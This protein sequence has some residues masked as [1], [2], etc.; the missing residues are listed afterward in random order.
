[1]SSSSDRTAGEPLTLRRAKRWLAVVAVVLVPLA[2]AFN[3]WIDMALVDGFHEGEYL[4]NGPKMRAYYAGLTAFPVLIHGAMD[5]LP[6]LAAERIAGLDRVIVWTRFINTA[7]VAMCWVLWMRVPHWLLRDKTR[8]PAWYLV[9]AL[10]FG[11]MAISAGTDPVAKQQAFLG[12][13]DVFLVVMV[14]LAAWASTIVRPGRAALVYV[15]TGA[16]AAACLYWSYDRGVIAFACVVLII[17]SL[18]LMKKFGQASGLAAG[19]CIVLAVVSACGWAGTLGENVHNVQYWLRYSSDVWRLT[20][21]N[22]IYAL[23]GVA[24]TAV[25][26]LVVLGAAVLQLARRQLGNLAPLATALVAAQLVF[27]SKMS[28]LAPFPNSYYTVWPA[29]LLLLIVS[30]RWPAIDAIAAGVAAFGER[31]NNVWA[32]SRGATLQ[33]VALAGLVLMF[34]AN[35]IGGSVIL[36]KKLAKPPEDRWLITAHRFG[37]DDVD[38]RGASCIFQ[39]ANEGIFA[40]VAGKPFCTS[41][42][43]AVYIAKHEEAGVLEEMRRNP[44]PLIVYDNHS[45]TMH[46]YYRTMKE[47]LPAI[48]RFIQENYDIKSSA[49]GYEFALLKATPQGIKAP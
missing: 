13:R 14:A 35:T 5:F 42:G 31:W 15:A 12:T 1:M 49:A 46:I 17:A 37:M 44:P 19:Y 18:V 34:A 45:W 22:N 20:L 21:R 29:L 47:R 36:A 41:Y 10:L 43:Y 26:A 28:Q 6:A 23:P 40:F 32:V 27:L 3:V 30:P 39:W 2:L 48:D 7:C 24:G 8:R 38:L 16:A 11:W 9:H 4:T 25:F 33:R